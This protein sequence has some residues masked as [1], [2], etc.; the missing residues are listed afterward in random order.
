MGKF[1]RCAGFIP[2]LEKGSEDWSD[3]G[4]TRY[5][6]RFVS[7]FDQNMALTG[8]VYLIYLET[9]KA[10]LLRRNRKESQICGGLSGTPRFDVSCEVI[11]MK[12]YE[13]IFYVWGTI[14][15]A[16]V[17]RERSLNYIDDPLR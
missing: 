8:T 6:Y 10:D 2:N 11:D 4:N 13:S 12:L 5:L 1:I 16:L 7:A 14:R 9:W 17:D 15:R 3:N